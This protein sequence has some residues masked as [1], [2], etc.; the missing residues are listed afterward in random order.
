MFLIYLEYLG[1]IEQSRQPSIAKF[2]QEHVNIYFHCVRLEKTSISYRL[3]HCDI[4]ALRST[5]EYI[6]Y[7]TNKLNIL[8]L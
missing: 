4:Y 6:L 2:E 8:N 1:Q 3:Y 7:L 5:F